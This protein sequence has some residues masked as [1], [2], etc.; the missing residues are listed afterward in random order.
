MSKKL[1]RALALLVG[2]LLVPLLA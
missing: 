2:I 1:F